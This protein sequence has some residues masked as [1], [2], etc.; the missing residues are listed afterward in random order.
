MAVAWL[1]DALTGWLGA[2]LGWIAAGGAVWFF[3]G[4][5]AKQGERLD[6]A[7]DNLDAA[8]RA[9]DTRHEVETSDDQ[10]LVDILSGKLHNN[11]R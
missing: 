2:A 9:K 10:R 3:A 4:R 6:R 8:K 1:L 7:E 5:S 11:K